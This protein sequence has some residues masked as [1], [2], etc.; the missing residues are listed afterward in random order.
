MEEYKFIK[1]KREA[2]QMQVKEYYKIK[3]DFVVATLLDTIEKPYWY[4]IGA[5]YGDV[6]CVKDDEI[7]LKKKQYKELGLKEWIKI[8]FEPPTPKKF[9]EKNITNDFYKFPK[10]CLE[11]VIETMFSKV[12]K[13]LKG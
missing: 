10:D 5:E 8:Q 11:K 3:Y 7:L 4:P 13:A 12:C 6:I 1:S 2:K 9:L